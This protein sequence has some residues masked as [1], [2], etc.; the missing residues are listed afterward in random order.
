MVSTIARFG[1]NILLTATLLVTIA[2]L[3]QII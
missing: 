2:L 1:H 3:R